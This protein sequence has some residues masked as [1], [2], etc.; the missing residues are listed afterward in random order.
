M[1][2]KEE[3]GAYTQRNE[4]AVPLDHVSDAPACMRDPAALC[5]KVSAQEVYAAM[6]VGDER[7]EGRGSDA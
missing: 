5:L 1:K 4:D 3:D 7:A 6:D 2:Y